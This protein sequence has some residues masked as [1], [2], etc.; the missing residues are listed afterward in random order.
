MN[1]Y[2]RVALE[3]VIN[4]LN[5]AK[6][7]LD[8]HLESSPC[9]VLLDFDDTDTI[10]GMR[11]MLKFGPVKRCERAGVKSMEKQMEIDQGLLPSQSKANGGRALCGVDYVLDWLRATVVTKDPYVLYVTFMM[12]EECKV[13][14]IHRVKNKFFDPEYPP[15]I[16]TNALINLMLL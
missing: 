5:S 13:L 4:M 1:L 9:S 7:I 12:L 15:N 8:I 2:Y 6:S 16:Q 14:R 3:T 10:Q 11:A